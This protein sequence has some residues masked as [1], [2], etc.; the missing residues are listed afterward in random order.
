M[1]RRRPQY[2]HVV[3]YVSVR[4]WSWTD[5]TPPNSNSSTRARVWKIIGRD[6]RPE[7]EDRWLESSDNPPDC[8]RVRIE[9][10]AVYRMD[11][12]PAGITWCPTCLS[13]QAAERFLS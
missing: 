3:D 7:A 12:T 2:V 1:T 4:L 13:R 8:R 9:D 10:V 11:D 5:V 6:P